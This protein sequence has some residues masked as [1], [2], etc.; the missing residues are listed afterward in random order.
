MIKFH[1]EILLDAQTSDSLVID[2][3]RYTSKEH[4]S[5]IHGG[6]F[7][8]RNTSDEFKDLLS[9]SEPWNKLYRKLSSN[10]FLSSCMEHLEMSSGAVELNPYLSQRIIP[11]KLQRV[12]ALKHKR[13]RETSFI[14]MSA[15]L[16]YS[17]WNKFCFYMF[18]LRYRFS[19]KIQLDILLD[20]SQSENGYVR[21]IHRDSDSKYVVFLLYL[22]DLSEKGEGGELN[23]FKYTGELKHDPEPQPAAEN[24]AL[25]RKITPTKGK[26][27]IF[28]NN[29]EAFHSVSEMSGYDEGRI[30]C[31]GAYT[32]LS[33]ANPNFNKSTRKLKTQ[34]QLYI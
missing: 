8:L 7:I 9:K 17:L 20:V 29:H 15:Y 23:L 30:F 13:I 3:Q 21:E 34:W 5:D 33:G 27:I 28:K 32:V 6:R 31:Q 24:C 12:D 18:R 22:T 19:K 1:E 2:L 14:A 16:V 10:E 4:L 26:L 11:Q 25:M